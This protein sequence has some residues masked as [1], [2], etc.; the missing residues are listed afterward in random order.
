MHLYTYVQVLALP[1]L[2]ERIAEGARGTPAGRPGERFVSPIS[3][4]KIPGRFYLLFGAPIETGAVDAADREACAA[5]CVELLSNV[6]PVRACIHTC[7]LM[8][9]ARASSCVWHVHPHACGTCTARV[10]RWR[11]RRRC[12][13]SRSA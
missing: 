3:L 5:L 4:P 8:C 2:G 12:A 7:I 13:R 11:T 6:P 9:M 10:R 1:V